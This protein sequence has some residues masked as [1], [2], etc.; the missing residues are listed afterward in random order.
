[1]TLVAWKPQPGPQTLFVQCPAFECLYGGSLGGG[2]TDA[3][4][5]DYSRGID[6]GAAWVGVFLR[7]HRPDMDDVIRRSMAI[8]GPVYGAECYNGSKYQWNFPTGAVLQFRAAVRDLE[9]ETKFQGQQYQWVGFDELTQWPTPYQYTYL[10][11]R[12]RSAGNVKPR[13]RAA[14]NPGG[15]GHHWVK[16]RFIDPVPPGVPQK[17]VSKK[18][19]KALYR[20]FVPAKLADNRILCASDPEYADRVTEN[21][22]PVLAA[23]LID[24]RWDILHGAAFTEWN[25]SVHVIDPAPIPTDKKIWRALDW[26][27]VEP[28]AAGWFFEYDG[29]V[30]MGH[31]IYGWG[32]KANVGSREPATEVR[33]KIE[34]YEQMNELWV[35]VGL[36]DGQTKEQHGSDGGL[37]FDLLGGRDLGW[38]AWPKGPHSRVQQKQNFHQFLSVTNGSSRFKV[39]RHC[40]HTIRTIPSLPADRN[41]LE[42]VDTNAEDHCYDMIRGALTMKVRTRDELRKRAMRR[43]MRNREYISAGDLEYGGF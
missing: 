35:P 9:V 30:I 28:Y 12:L 32:G 39:M 21:I 4:L 43:K 14:T 3:L 25:P 8:F 36:V 5:G 42:D 15:V 34:N 17:I 19:G 13:I 23:A 24:G 27:F 16:E 22:D 41:N 31:E 40:K 38:K 1:M 10:I 29:D 11:T 33:R 20:V 2:K 6:K 18:T 37:I 7:Q 26:G